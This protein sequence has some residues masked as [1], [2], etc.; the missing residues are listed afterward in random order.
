MRSYTSA[1]IQC[2]FQRQQ[3]EKSLRKLEVEI[4]ELWDLYLS[5]RICFVF[6]SCLLVFMFFFLNFLAFHLHVSQ[7][8]KKSFSQSRLLE[9]MENWASWLPPDESTRSRYLVVQKVGEIQLHLHMP[10]PKPRFRT[11]EMVLRQ[12]AALRSEE[13]A[14]NSMRQTKGRRNYSPHHAHWPPLPKVQ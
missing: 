5:G 7:A 4:N 12:T 8:N 9:N 10:V 13:Q 6:S 3:I 2:T 11:V 1:K 14:I